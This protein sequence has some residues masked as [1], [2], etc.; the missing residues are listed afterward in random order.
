MGP[1]DNSLTVSAEKN[2]KIFF[3]QTG[4]N[5]YRCDRTALRSRP[6]QEILKS[7]SN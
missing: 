3:V 5:G 2:L 7:H 1:N 4:S 6:V